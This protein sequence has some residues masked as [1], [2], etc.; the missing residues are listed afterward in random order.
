MNT[1][2]YKEQWDKLTKAYINDEV[3][4]YDECACF[5]GNLLNGSSN[6]AACRMG[7]AYRGASKV[8][9]DATFNDY[10]TSYDIVALENT[11]MGIIWG[12]VRPHYVIETGCAYAYNHLEEKEEIL[13]KAFEKTLELLKQIH[14]SKGEN[15][16]EEFEFKKR[17]LAI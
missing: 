1:P 12:Y 9:F 5:V 2:S 8:Y 4:P 7:D 17:Q 3:N 15:V 16:E 14:I 11:F 13:F 6:W 10:Y